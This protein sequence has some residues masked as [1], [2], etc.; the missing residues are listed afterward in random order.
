MHNWN[1]IIVYFLNSI[2]FPPIGQLIFCIKINI[3]QLK[4]RFL[5]LFD[6]LFSMIGKKK[7]LCKWIALKI[8][9][10]KGNSVIMRKIE[11]AK[12]DI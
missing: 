8:M 5:H 4:G 2:A 12:R 3:V 6:Y 10:K 7:N 11:N 9:H 1:K